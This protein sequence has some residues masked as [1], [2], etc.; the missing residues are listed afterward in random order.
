[1]A[2]DQPKEVIEQKQ[3]LTKCIVHTL[4]DTPQTQTVGK[5]KK[6]RTIK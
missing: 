3:S 1:M 5:H 4:R 6:M 2:I